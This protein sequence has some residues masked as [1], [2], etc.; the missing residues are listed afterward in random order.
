MCPVGC[1][2]LKASRRHSARSLGGMEMCVALM[3][4]VLGAANVGTVMREASMTDHSHGRGMGHAPAPPDADAPQEQ[5]RRSLRPLGVGIV[6]GLAGSAAVALLVLGTIRD[7]VLGVVYL[8]VFGGGTIVGMSL[9]TMALAVPVVVV[10]G[11]FDHLRR[12]LGTVAGFASVGFGVFLIHEIGF[13]HGLFTG[14]ADWTP[15]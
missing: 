5:P 2:G 7:P 15:Q 13:V 8:L 6:H 11:R 9:I 4:V 10:A 14:D 3:L 12:M 1:L